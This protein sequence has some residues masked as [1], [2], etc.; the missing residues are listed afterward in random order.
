MATEKDFLAA[1]A[2][3]V[4]GDL[5]LNGVVVGRHRDG[6]LI[7]TEEGMTMEL[8]AAPAPAVE[9]AAPA[10]TKK[11]HKAKPAA[12]PAAPETPPPS[13]PLSELDQLK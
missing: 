5:I 10:T 4:C 13:D 3:Y 2:D 1:G 12:Q 7:V 11:P 8:P 9:P 6:K